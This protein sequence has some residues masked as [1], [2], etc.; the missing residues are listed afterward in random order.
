MGT[1]KNVLLTLKGILHGLVILNDEDT[2]DE[3]GNGKRF[4]A[5]NDIFDVGNLAQNM[6]PVLSIIPAP[7]TIKVGISGQDMDSDFRIAIFG[8]INRSQNET[9]FIAGENAIEVIIKALTTQS[10]IDKMSEKLF[11]IVQIGPILNEAY[12]EEGISNGLA[13]ISVPVTVQFLEN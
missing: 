6:F 11:S 1:R 4:Y 12:S 13:Y 9:L 3:D 7:E 8:Y 2:L 5:E 10:N